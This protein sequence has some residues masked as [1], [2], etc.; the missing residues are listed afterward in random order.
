MVLAL[1]V[2]LG[3]I[4]VVVAAVEYRDSRPVLI[5]VYVPARYEGWVV[6]AWN[7]PG[8]A[9]LRDAFVGGRRYELAASETGSVCLAD[10]IPAT[11][12]NLLRYGLSGTSG[13]A[14]V[15]RVDPVNVFPDTPRSPTLDPRVGAA[16]G[17]HYDIAWVDIVEDTPAAY[18]LGDQCDLVEYLT[19]TFGEPTVQV[20]CGLIPTRPSAGLSGRDA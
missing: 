11:G 14:P 3:T 1:F 17:V 15:F 10:P 12:F 19:R 8:G 18:A 20:P 4:G 16:S 7:C 9:R 5:T 2:L 13:Y 6:V